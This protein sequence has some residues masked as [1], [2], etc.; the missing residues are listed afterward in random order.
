MTQGLIGQLIG[1]RYR[2]TY[3]VSEGGYGNV[4]KAV[5]TQMED[6]L[7]AVKLLRSPPP[8][9]DEDYYAQ[10]QQRFMDEAR[11]SALLGEHPNIV[12]V[13]SYGMHHNRPYLVMEYLN[14]KPYVGNGLDYILNR[15]GTLE[16][17]RV[18][19]LALQICSALYHAHCFQ[20]DL[21]R[22]SIRGVVHRDIK[23]SNIFALRAPGQAEK[24]KLLD[25][26]ISKLLNDTG[27]GLTQ[28]GYFLGTM[29]YSSPEQ[30]RGET[31]DGR[32][33]IYSLGVVLYELLTGSLPL[34]PETDSLQGWYHVH[35]FQKPRP[36][37]DFRVSQGIPVE[38][39]RVIMQCLAKEAAN[40]PANM[41]E[42]KEQLQ[43][44]M[45]EAELTAVPPP[46]P[47]GNGNP[48]KPA[49]PPSSKPAAPK[50]VAAKP[51]DVPPV[52]SPAPSETPIEVAR[53]LIEQGHWRD[54]IYILNR[55][56]QKEPNEA[57]YYLYRGLA[58]QQLGDWGLAQADFHGA[59]RLDPDH[60][61]AQEGLKAVLAQQAAGATAPT[62]NQSTINPMRPTVEDPLKD[63]QQLDTVEVAVDWRFWPLWMLAN[64]LAFGIAHAG[65][66]GILSYWQG[67]TWTSVVYGLA[68]GTWL[69]LVT[70]L[71]QWLVLRPW[72]RQP[73][74]WM[75]ATM[76]AYG[77]GGLGFVLLHLEDA[78]MALQQFTLLG[79]PLI[80]LWVGILLGSLQW[81]LLRQVSARGIWWI[82][83]SA[84][85]LG[86]ATWGMTAL[87]QREIPLFPGLALLGMLLY[88]RP[89]AGYCLTWLLQHPHFA[90]SRDQSPQ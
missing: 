17:A 56:I 89:L 18:V 81:W 19:R 27:K 62:T 73:A 83:I 8:D 23:P 30:M 67:D 90:K 70:G 64:A 12:Q 21:G 24:V 40:R 34:N 4:F 43:A 49:S 48:A 75:L 88:C 76:L 78:K 15:E 45:P 69:G 6:Q 84:L 28:E 66:R 85:E 39:Q 61:E 77:L 55:M 37:R 79:S 33:D 63:L 60:R 82:A 71:A 3:H 54:A 2:L 68:I 35:N 7:V 22:Y 11:V 87:S 74:G 86:L 44:A 20:M 36:L 25:F 14:A 1:N 9:M 13:K 46:L 10:L 38:L 52:A 16:P 65:M 58:H 53:R 29:C 42:L 31:L 57:N 50:P 41:M 26:G 59:L 32:S 72:L 47:K 51:A 80:G 5:D